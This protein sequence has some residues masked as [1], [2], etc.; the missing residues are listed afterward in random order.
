MFSYDIIIVAQK[1]HVAVFLYFKQIAKERRCFPTPFFF[2]TLL[3]AVLWS[4]IIWLQIKQRRQNFLMNTV[5]LKGIVKSIPEKSAKGYY[6]FELGIKRYSG[7]EDMIKVVFE[8]AMSN[9]SI[10]LGEPVAILGSI[11][12]YS[13]YDVNARKARTLIR[14]KASQI[15][16][17]NEFEDEYVNVVNIFDNTFLTDPVI[18]KTPKNIVITDF[19]LVNKEGGVVT[20]HIPCIAW[21]GVAR[22][23]V[24]IGNWGKF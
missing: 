17:G 9:F 22:K 8:D 24:A 12:S 18:R 20:A 10:A 1:N 16:D 15:T 14:V 23:L 3:T 2:L 21:N 13:E 6:E 4:V 7:Y 5:T 19:V 11:I